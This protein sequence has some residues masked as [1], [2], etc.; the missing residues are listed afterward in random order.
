ML[1]ALEIVGGIIVFSLLIII[2]ELGHFWTAKSFNIKVNEF[3]VGMGP[4]LWKKQKGETLYAVRCV[5]MGGYCKMEGEDESSPEPRAFGNAKAWKRIVVLAAGGIMNLIAGLLLCFV[6]L[7]TTHNIAVPTVGSFSDNSPLE[8]AGLQVGDQIISIDGKI[9]HT[10]QDVQITTQLSQNQKKIVYMH[11][12]VRQTAYVTPVLNEDSGTYML[13]FTSGYVQ[14]SFV[15]TIKY[16]WYQFAS[17]SEQII[18]TLVR[19]V[20]GHLNISQLSGPVGIAGVIGGAV[21]GVVTQS[22]GTGWWFLAYVFILITINLGIFNLIPFPALDG[23]R[24]FFVLVEL[25]RRKPIKA[26]YEGVVHVI[27]FAAL[28]GLII[29]VTGFDIFRLFPS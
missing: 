18:S 29:V 27:G 23:G 11:D 4:A 22:G 10:T 28:I 17:F 21:G 25:V 16:G 1:L 3:A 9:V 8:A 15:N 24:I 7:A 6:L 2:H 19:L 20:T 26:E 12:G 5:P 13:G 14:N